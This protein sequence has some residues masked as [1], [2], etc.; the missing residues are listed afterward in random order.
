MKLAII[1]AGD[2]AAAKPK[3]MALGGE[4]GFGTVD[5][6]RIARL[7]PHAMLWIHLALNHGFG[8]DWGLALER[9]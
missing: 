7:E 4:L 6:G 8:G 5:A 3:V 1:G 9:H 2:D